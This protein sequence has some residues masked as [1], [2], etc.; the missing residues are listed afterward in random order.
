MAAIGS[1]RWQ[2][3]RSV[4][5]EPGTPEAVP[6]VRSWRTASGEAERA[7]CPAPRRSARVAGGFSIA[8]TS[9][10]IICDS[11]TR[12]R[13]RAPVSRGGQPLEHP[14][15]GQQ[16]VRPPVAGA[17][18][19]P[20]PQHRA[21]QPG[22]RQ[23]LLGL[24]PRLLIGLHHR[25]RLGDADVDEVRD[26]RRRAPRRSIPRPIADRSPGTAVALLGE[27]CGTPTSCTNVSHGGIAPAKVCR[28]NG[29]PTIDLAAARAPW[30]RSH[31]AP[32]RGPD[33]PA[34][35]GRG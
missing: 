21:R 19:I 8:R 20:R 33:V 18:H 35:A 2:D 4:D 15:R 13:R 11:V 31:D 12:P 3:R 28:S 10:S 16:Q 22:G 24:A 6:Y 26:A 17:E 7:G 32:A 1:R 9:A 14:V 29:S 25:R 30:P 34:R 23:A 5:L 27:G